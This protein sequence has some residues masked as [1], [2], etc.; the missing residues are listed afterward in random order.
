[1][2]ALFKK[3][4]KIKLSLPTKWCQVKD[5]RPFIWF[6]GTVIEAD[7]RSFLANV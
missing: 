6:K 5:K 7:D 3:G 1:M 2:D 4:D